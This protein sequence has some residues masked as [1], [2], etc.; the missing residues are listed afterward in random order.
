MKISSYTASGL[1][2][3]TLPSMSLSTKSLNGT[4]KVVG[5]TIGQ[6]GKQKK[7]LNY[8][9][10]EISSALL[11]A[12]K[13]QS[14]GRVAV[15][16]KNKLSSLVKCKGTG[17]YDEGELNMA[18]AHAKRMVQCAQMKTRNLRQE[19][20]AKK[21]YENEAKRELRQEKNEA[22][23]RAT[24]KEQNQE[25]K[26]KLERTQRIQKQKS[27]KRELM[28]K[29]KFHR[30]RE[31]SEVNEADF[32]YLKQQIRNMREP[33]STSAGSSVGVTLELSMAAA[34]LTE[35]QL[36]QQI[37]QQ[38]TEVEGGIGATGVPES[39]GGLSVTP[40]TGIDIIV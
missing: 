29:K 2:T 1:A 13:S 7:K 26:N 9:P 36:N 31:Q 15:Q 6:N 28:R 11:R 34:Q 38:M 35:A 30:S 32:K 22:K 33:Y 17:K 23:A 16:A 37:E 18:I 40:T 21:Q 12:K 8:N 10:R 4:S 27:R 5:K 19:E 25:Q 3:G 14:A 20:R 39:A 24:R